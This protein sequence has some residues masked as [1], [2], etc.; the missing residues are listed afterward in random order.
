MDF[1]DAMSDDDYGI[2]ISRNGDLKGLFVPK[3]VETDEE[4]PPSIVAIIT[5]VF[6]LDLDDDE[7][8]TI[9]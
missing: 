3:I 9:H 2:I 8:K 4:V 1:Q 5:D 7:I 6:G